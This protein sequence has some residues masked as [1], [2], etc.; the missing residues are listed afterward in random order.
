MP[1]SAVA[2][3]RQNVR[4]LLMYFLIIAALPVNLATVGTNVK[5]L[6]FSEHRRWDFLNADTG[7]TAK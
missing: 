2:I 5:H 3:I 1:R 7:A 6:H 4:K